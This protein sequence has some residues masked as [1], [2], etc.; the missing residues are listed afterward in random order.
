MEE[1][2]AAVDRGRAAFTYGRVLELVVHHERAS[3][4]DDDELRADGDPD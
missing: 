4:A 1:P 3:C 2:G